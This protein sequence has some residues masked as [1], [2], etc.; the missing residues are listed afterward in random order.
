MSADFGRPGQ[1]G[2]ALL[3]REREIEELRNTLTEA[4][5]GRGRL[6][7]IEAA[8]GL[9][10]TTLLRTAT[11]AAAETGFT[12]LRARAGELERDF[13]YGCVR[14]LLEPVITKA[15]EADR[16]RLLEGAAALSAPLFEPHGIGAC[17]PPSAD[18][19]FAM[20]HGLYWLLN[21]LASS[22]PVVLAIDDLHWA[23]AESLRFLNYL[24]PRLDGMRVA[25]L[26]GTRPEPTIAVDVARLTASPDLR[27]LR[28]EPLSV[29]AT[30]KLCERAFGTPAEPAFAAACRDATGGNPFF[31]EALLR[32]A[33]AQ[34]LSTHA[35]DAARVR[36][37]GPPA[38]ARAVL[39][40]LTGMP[41]AATALVRACA[42]LG[43]TAG[44]REAA[45]LA[46]ISL[47]EAARLIDLLIARAVLKPAERIAFVHPIVREAVYADIGA[48][49]RARAHGRAARVLAELGADDE[50]V[51]A[52]IAAAEPTGDAEA[53]ALLR[54]VAAAALARG[55]PAAAVA[56]LRRALAEPPSLDCRGEVLLELG[57][58][59]L[60]MAAPEAAQ[61]LSAAFPML[62]EP[63]LLA[64]CARHFAN[65][66][67]MTGEFDRA[68]TVLESAADAV[69]PQDRE[70]ALLLTAE[71]AAKAQQASR[72]HRARAAQRLTRYV[73]LKGA[74]PG[75]RLV[76]ASRAFEL[77]RGC[78][79]ADDAARH[80]ERELADGR[81][82]REQDI[83]VAG[84]FY[85]LLIALLATDAL[86]LA[87]SC[88]EQALAD[89]RARASIPALAFLLA[90]RSRLWLR[91]G[92]LAQAEAD[93]RSALEL[94]NAH[95]I[96]LGN[97]FAMAVLISVLVERG[98]IEEAERTLA[99][100]ALGQDIPPGLAANDLLEA[101]GLLRLAENRS[102][103]GLQDL[104]EFGRRDELWGGNSPLASR[105]RSRACIAL[106]AA[107]DLDRA[108]SL[109]DEDV[110]R[111]RRW[112]AASGIGIALH[113]KALTERSTRTI[114][115]LRESLAMLES[116][117]ARL[118]QARVLVDLGAALR[119]A[120]R[121]TDARGALKEG[122]KLAGL[123]DAGALGARARVELRAAGGR[124]SDAAGTGY[125]GLTV[126]ELRVAELAAK[127]C[128]NP[129]I[130]QTLFVTRKTVET[131]LGHV[132]SKLAISGRTELFRA[133][134]KERA[135]ANS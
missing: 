87:D 96:R 89:A 3:E 81:L 33:N 124:A 120:N 36:R 43:D 6:V 21:N 39:L 92:A 10:K 114:A 85:A 13:A 123:C 16:A 45:R 27:L 61:H 9:G 64:T 67:N 116:S 37:L 71:L 26:A 5:Q 127:G 59:E 70:L 102:E 112:G 75:E 8:A 11:R 90:H 101:R 1:D 31:L 17:S 7:L 128:S 54:R 91:R 57:S 69:E 44:T 62:R 15:H 107:G 122:L 103:A 110:E 51:A 42:V 108:R 58:A 46:E 106:V 73:D 79:A 34:A 65:A 125:H 53:V 68:V 105:W 84:P 23:D 111:A 29:D 97:R 118:E 40:R 72:E 14:Q 48:N 38:V 109:A 63:R 93:A 82:L 80:I 49:E 55:A 78:D 32:E 129:E 94:L 77:A 25:V 66:L 19:A 60:R 95:D 28:L 30:A 98:E 131:H 126:A 18:S 100:S 99:S 12:C 135:S 56:Y 74:T 115:L 133:L 88:I 52:Q 113:A 76:R 4:E 117:P 24:T 41:R 132:Y 130:A 86:D 47:E 104:F 50:R 35:L 20:L 134:A 119:R 121:R 22:A 2:A 83:D